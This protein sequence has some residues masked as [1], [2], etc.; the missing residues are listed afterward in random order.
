MK[1]FFD[2]KL[3][4]NELPTIVKV[5]GGNSYEE[6]R[7]LIVID[8]GICEFAV[9]QPIKIDENKRVI[10]TGDTFLISELYG[11]SFEIIS[12][13][14]MSFMKNDSRIFRKYKTINERPT[15]HDDE[16]V[17]FKAA[18]CTE[19]TETEMNSL[20]QEDSSLKK[21][22]FPPTL[23]NVVNKVYNVI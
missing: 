19:T 16:S 17:G 7:I 3:S 11:G 15:T 1:F 21:I 8:A 22:Q 23:S 14:H 9:L 12:E 6:S 2:R 5:K 10:R 13:N 20:L 18:K 4:H